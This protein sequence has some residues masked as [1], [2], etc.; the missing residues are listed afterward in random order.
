MNKA[1][2]FSTP[3]ANPLLADWSERP[4]ETP[5]FERIETDQF[6][7]AFETAL[8]AH[9]AEIAAIVANPDEPDFANTI[10]ALE[11]AGRTL[12][13]V[14]DVF[15]ALAG[16]NT[17]DAIEEIERD[18]S[19]KLAAHFSRIYLDTALF[20]RVD[21]LFRKRKSLGPHPRAGPGARALSHR[22]P[23]GRRASG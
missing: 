13:R 17:N 19:P 4:F 6:L 1:A 10:E 20:G 5:P 21:A 12:G 23:P 14:S 11:R 8:A 3:A 16:A 15:F 22:L 9:D 2:Q 7:P 18:I